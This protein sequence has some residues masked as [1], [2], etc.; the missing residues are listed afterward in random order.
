MRERRALSY[1]S[2]PVYDTI[3][4]TTPGEMQSPSLKNVLRGVERGEV[5]VFATVLVGYC[6]LASETETERPR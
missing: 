3:D 5:C 2:D 4:Y 1:A 6:A